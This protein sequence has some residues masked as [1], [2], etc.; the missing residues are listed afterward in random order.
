A[1]G[2]LNNQLVESDGE[3]FLIKGQSY[4]RVIQHTAEQ[5][6]RSGTQITNTH[7]ETV[8]TKITTLSP[9]GEIV[10]RDGADLQDFLT[11]WLPHLTDIVATSYPPRYQFD[12]NGYGDTLSTLN[13]GRLIPL[14]G[15]PGLLPAQAH[16]AAAIA[17]QLKTHRAAI[18][19]GEMGVG[20][21]LVGIA[22]AACIK[23][24]RT[25]ILCPPHLVDK[26]IRESKVVWPAATAV[27]LKTITDVD[28]FFA[29]PGP[30]VGVMKETTA[31]SATG[32][33]HAF[34][35]FGPTTMPT[36]SK[37]DAWEFTRSSTLAPQSEIDYIA[38]AE[39][40][41]KMTK[42]VRARCPT[43]GELT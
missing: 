2:H 43:C 25:I 36:R 17:T 42:Y 6:T 30:I 15:K 7:T 33:S 22:V 27:P 19:V 1:A 24:K 16:A 21:T 14:V 29:H 26:W 40:E 34:N 12:L 18:C 3:Q 8:V 28:N 11:T 35:W 5:A 41:N 9:E 20:K 32:W 39:Q 31:R 13:Q 37:D 23:A 4:K 38:L 10:Q